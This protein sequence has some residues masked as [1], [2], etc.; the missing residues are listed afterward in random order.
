MSLGREPEDKEGCS[1][2]P[3]IPEPCVFC[4]AWRPGSRLTTAQGRGP[5]VAK[6]LLFLSPTPMCWKWLPV[7]N[8]PVPGRISRLSGKGCRDGLVMSA[9]STEVE[10][11]WRVSATSVVQDAFVG[12]ISIQLDEGVALRQWGRVSGH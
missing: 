10:Y 12:S 7:Y 2:D 6:E 1:S 11:R 3:T 5:G 4:G 8:S 9:T